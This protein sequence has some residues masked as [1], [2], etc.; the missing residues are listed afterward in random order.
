MLLSLVSLTVASCVQMDLHRATS[1]TAN[2]KNRSRYL[3]L[4]PTLV[5]ELRI[6]RLQRLLDISSGR[7][8]GQHARAVWRLLVDYE[9]SPST[10]TPRRSLPWTFLG[11]CVV[12]VRR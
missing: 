12:G 4:T 5:V 9:M 10:S 6:T 7:S 1:S 8:S 2:T 3:A 11:L